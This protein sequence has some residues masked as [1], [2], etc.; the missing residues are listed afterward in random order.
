MIIY[1]IICIN[2]M[3][4]IHRQIIIIN[5]LILKLKKFKNKDIYICLLINLNN[6]KK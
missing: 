5:V 2:S 1:L 3:N 6:I 4:N